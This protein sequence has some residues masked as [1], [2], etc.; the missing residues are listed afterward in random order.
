MKG[1]KSLFLH[2]FCAVALIMS[3][4]MAA[5]GEV[6]KLR[7]ALNGSEEH[8]FVR[9]VRILEKKLKENSNGRFAVEVF[10]N[11]ILG[12]ER[13]MIEQTIMGSIEMFVGAADGATPAWVPNTQIFTVPY[14]FTS[15][16]EARKAS[17]NLL[18]ELL[19]PGFNDA[20]LKNFGFFELGFRH[21]TNNKHSVASAADM[22]GLII[23]VQESAAWQTLMQRLGSTPTPMPINE[24]YAAMQQG[25]VDGQENP[26][27]TIV[28]QKFYEV[29]KHLVLDGHTYGAGVV[30]M[31]L[32]FYNTLSDADK[33]FI[34]KC[35]N[36]SIVE[37][38]D[39]VEREEALYLKTVKDN[40]MQVVENPD[41][42][43]FQAAVAGFGEDPAI[44]VLFDTSLITRVNN[45]LAGK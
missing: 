9:G 2:V 4:G 12:A 3:V 11:S 6:V 45:F 37:Q 22:K 28:S 40:G 13:E 19:E 41:L 16:V 30:L 34:A 26:L 15:R 17:D 14:L 38:R 8:V 5:A 1:K 42:A 21:F 18:L 44:K 35:V 20:G 10:P 43:S 32:D 29:Q 7:I 27:G 33:A 36:E 25:V 23:R 31:N 39:L 24:L